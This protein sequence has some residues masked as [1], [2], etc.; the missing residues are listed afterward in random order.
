M[1][2]LVTLFVSEITICCT[3]KPIHYLFICFRRSILFVMESVAVEHLRR[4]NRRLQDNEATTQR[5]ARHLQR[6]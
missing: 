2:S 5:D 4:S 6:R 1:T 3:L